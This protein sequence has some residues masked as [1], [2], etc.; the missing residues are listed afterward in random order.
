MR[1]T[2]DAE[3]REQTAR[4]ALRCCCEECVY[5]DATTDCCAHEWPTAEH[6]R[7]RLASRETT[8]VVFCKEF[9][10]A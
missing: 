8:Q 9:E 3:L 4:Y 10:L 5:L 7:A 6:R 2:V 1:T